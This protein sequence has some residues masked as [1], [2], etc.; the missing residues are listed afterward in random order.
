MM[1]TTLK[2]QRRKSVEI[3]VELI[4]RQKLFEKNDKCWRRLKSFNT[5]IG[6][7]E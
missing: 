7:T 2:L 4:K 5:V 6:I 3:E 1:P